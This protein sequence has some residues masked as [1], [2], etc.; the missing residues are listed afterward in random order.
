MRIQMSSNLS[1]RARWTVGFASVLA[2]GAM[3][4]YPGGTVLDRTSPGYSLSRNFL[5][6]LGMTVAYDRLPNRLGAGLF[7]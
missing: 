1:R 5:S 6:D 7:V 3:T 2:I 4:R